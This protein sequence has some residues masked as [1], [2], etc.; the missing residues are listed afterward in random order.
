MLLSLLLIILLFLFIHKI[1]INQLL[2]FI[3]VLIVS[4]LFI[5][6]NII[7]DAFIIGV[8]TIFVGKFTNSNYDLLSLFFIGFTIHIFINNKTNTLFHPLPVKDYSIVHP[9]S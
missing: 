6:N 7:F 8:L 2:L 4:L 3:L 5:P 1:Y 9:A